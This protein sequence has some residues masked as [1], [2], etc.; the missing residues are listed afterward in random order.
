MSRERESRKRRPGVRA[1]MLL[2]VA[3]GLLVALAA[4]FLAGQRSSGETKL[5]AS[6]RYGFALA[7]P[8]EWRAKWMSE[9]QRARFG[10]IA[11]LQRGRPG[12]AIFIKIKKA[13]SVKSLEK[14][15]S[16]LDALLSKQ[17]PGFQKLSSRLLEI[18]NRQALRYAYTFKNVRK[19]PVMQEQVITISRGQ[20]HY[21]VLQTNP[22]DYRQ[23][24]GEFDKVINSLTLER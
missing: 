5:L 10:V 2:V 18:D 1:P 17:L 4:W 8:R 20:A 3:C 15:D 6:K 19:Q 16:A 14:T 23:V 9:K 11:V 24:S 7:Y 21:L 13:P 12:A 22:G